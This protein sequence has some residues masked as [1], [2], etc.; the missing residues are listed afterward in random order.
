M[1]EIPIPSNLIQPYP[2]NMYLNGSIAAIVAVLSVSI[3]LVLSPW[4]TASI[5]TSLEIDTIASVVRE[6]VR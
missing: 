5:E 2:P 6:K 3:A 1:W 4:N